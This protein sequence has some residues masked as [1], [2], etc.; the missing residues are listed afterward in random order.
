MN[1]SVQSCL[2]LIEILLTQPLA[3]HY[4]IFKSCPAILR[5]RGCTLNIIKTL[6]ATN[7]MEGK[8]IILQQII[9]FQTDKLQ[10][11]SFATSSPFAVATCPFN[12]DSLSSKKSFHGSVVR[13]PHL[14]RFPGD[15]LS[16]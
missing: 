1:K 12:A 16:S 10:S 8:E 5:Q 6:S 11:E 7:M 3:R 14:V 2:D 13:N 9:I 4:L 15:S